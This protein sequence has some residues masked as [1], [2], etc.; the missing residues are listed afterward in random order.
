MSG[1]SP[2]HEKSSGLGPGRGSLMIA[3]G[4]YFLRNSRRGYS[5]KSCSDSG[6]EIWNRKAKPYQ[7]LGFL[8]N[9]LRFA[10]A[11]QAQ[12]AK[13][14]RARNP[15]VSKSEIDHHFA[16]DPPGE[17]CNLDEDL[18]QFWVLGK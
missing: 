16:A 8:P 6:T 12:E 11:E 14:A 9:I 1:P 3:L 5:R 13:R 4:E 15:T 18:L 17:L 7:R 2:T 10:R